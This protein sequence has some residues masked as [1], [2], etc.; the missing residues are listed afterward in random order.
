[1]NSPASSDSSTQDEGGI[2]A[3]VQSRGRQD[4][5]K[6]SPGDNLKRSSAT[7]RRPGTL[8]SQHS[9]SGRSGQSSPAT[10]GATHGRRASFTRSHSPAVGLTAESRNANGS[11]SSISPSIN[12]RLRSNVRGRV[13]LPTAFEFRTPI[14]FT[15]RTLLFTVDSRKS[16]ESLLLIGSLIYSATKLSDDGQDRPRPNVWISIGTRSLAPMVCQR[17]MMLRY[18]TLYLSYYFFNLRF[19]DTYLDTHQGRATIRPCT[20]ILPTFYA[21]PRDQAQWSY[22]VCPGKIKFR[23]DDCSKE[24]P[25][26]CV[27]G[28]FRVY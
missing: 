15:L 18:R 7:K 25:V 13:M 6:T 3:P 11:Y 12:S 23:M 22:R 4:S 2:D 14:P 9:S 26:C 20:S 17:L 27:S 24:L 28:A 1:M 16:G 5:L 19:M 21:G 10:G 8:A